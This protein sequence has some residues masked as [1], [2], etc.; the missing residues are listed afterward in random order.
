MKPRLS[1]DTNVINARGGLPW[2][3]VL[4]R[5]RE[6]GKVEFLASTRLRIEAAKHPLPNALEKARGFRDSSEPLV[7]GQ[8][9][10][11]EAYWGS[12]YDQQPEFFEV[13]S[14][15]FP[16]VP[17]GTLPEGDANDVMHLLSHAG[18]RADIFVTDG[19][20]DFISGGK[21]ELLRKRFGIVVMT[22]EEAVPHL[23]STYGWPV[24]PNSPAG[25]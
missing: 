8:S 6:E 21:R 1:I 7:W 22:A 24:P 17:H 5:W 11:G 12:V 19:K 10:W 25:S 20:K 14:V 18:A 13:A 15:L 4:E 9:F 3:N 16:G 23:S 2:V